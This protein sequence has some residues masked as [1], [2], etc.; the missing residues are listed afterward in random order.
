M[1]KKVFFFLVIMLVLAVQGCAMSGTAKP[2]SAMSAEWRN[3]VFAEKM[4]AQMLGLK[5]NETDCHTI[6]KALAEEC[7]YSMTLRCKSIRR[8]LNRIGKIQPCETT[9]NPENIRSVMHS[10]GR[11]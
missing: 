7:G 4:R 1:N 11:R 9:Y 5:K 10:L 8:D 6:Y 2:S 3:K